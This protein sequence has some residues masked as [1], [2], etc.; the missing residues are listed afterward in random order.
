MGISYPERGSEIP[1]DSN[2]NLLLPDDY[3]RE[4]KDDIDF[5]L[6][7]YPSPTSSEL[8]RALADYHDLNQEQ[9]V[10]DNG[11]DAILDTVCKTFVSKNGRLGYFHPS[12]EMYPFSPLGMIGN[13][14]RSR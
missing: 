9:V 11:S 12:Y 10:I 4:I 1:L 7:K 8:K 3:Y 13:P 14:L 2:E 6:R 5:D